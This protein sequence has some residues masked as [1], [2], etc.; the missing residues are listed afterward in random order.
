MQKGLT[1]F[2]KKIFWCA[3][4]LLLSISCNA[5]ATHF[6]GLLSISAQCFLELTKLLL[7][8]EISRLL[9]LC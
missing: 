4:R 5:D 1:T 9:L 7:Y 3:F 8:A 6:F 2:F